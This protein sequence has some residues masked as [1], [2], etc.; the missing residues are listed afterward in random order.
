MSKNQSPLLVDELGNPLTLHSSAVKIAVRTQPS[1]KG[2][3]PGMT[4]IDGAPFFV[5][6]EAT[7]SD[8]GVLPT[9]CYRFQQVDANGRSVG[10]CAKITITHLDEIEEEE[11]E[12]T[13][14]SAEAQEIISGQ[15]KDN[16][17]LLAALLEAVKILS[18]TV[19]SMGKA[20]VGM[21]EKMGGVVDSARDSMD[22]A[23]GAGLSK[24]AQEIR[25]IWDTMPESDSNLA[26][27]LNSPVVMGAA[28]TI[29]KFVADAMKPD[30][31]MA[32]GGK[33]SQASIAAEAA[34]RAAGF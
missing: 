24:R 5:P 6:L 34:A 22:T 7:W 26:T 8:V 21:A 31:H 15:R 28:H 13:G 16:K 1:S 10:A 14:I 9:G 4:Y 2:G 27:V 17:D 29:Q 30:A 33:P 25:D 18:N 32:T 23:H 12:G 11:R 3:H 20:N 19:E